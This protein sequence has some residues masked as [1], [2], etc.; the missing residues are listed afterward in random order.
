MYESAGDDAFLREMASVGEVVEAAGDP[1]SDRV[2]FT[3]REAGGT[4]LRLYDD[5]AVRTLDD[6]A[7]LTRGYTH[8]DQRSL[9]WA[10]DGS[11]VV[12]RSACSGTATV[13]WVDAA[14]GEPRPVTGGDV[15]VGQPR[16][17]PD[18]ERLVA[19]SED[20]SPRALV[21][22]PLDG[23][24]GP[25][26]D[27]GASP[28]GDG[29]T[30]LC[31]D[32]VFYDPRWLDESTVV[33]ARLPPH[34]IPDEEMELVA[35]SLD[36]TV[37][38]RHATDGKA[39]APRPAP[40]GDGFA[41]C[42][43]DHGRTGLYRYGSGDV[44]SV[45]A[46]DDADVRTPA[47]SE[48]GRLAVTAFADTNVELRVVNPDGTVETVADAPGRRHFPVW[49]DGHVCAVTSTPTRPFRLRDETAGRE[50]VADRLADPDRL[51]VPRPVECESRDGTAVPATVYYPPG[52]EDAPP[53][54]V[55]VV[56][57][58]HGGPSIFF[59][60]E[61]DRRP[62]YVAGR[63]YV[64]VEPNYRGSSGYGRAFRHASKG[65]WGRGDVDDLVAAADHLAAAHEQ[66]A[67]DRVGL[68]GM[69]HGG[70]LVLRALVE[71]DRFAAGATI[72]GICDLP[73]FVEESDDVGRWFVVGEM[74]T[75]DEHPDR[76]E[77]LSPIHRVDEIDAPVLVVHGAEDD[78][79][80]VS[81]S[82]RL[83]AALDDAG[84]PH[85]YVEFPDEGHVFVGVET[86][87]ATYSRVADLFDGAL[88]EGRR[89]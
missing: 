56:E 82:E 31:A 37:E 48:D 85:E 53:G 24:G 68:F 75:P 6:A 32:H 28:D 79:V 25:V 11:G 49:R 17:S 73:R 80:P 60:Y 8:H 67:G 45:Y 43:D 83:V 59:G 19:V 88:R 39:F 23:G 65:S 41:F 76:Y 2:A 27:D 72:C 35:V 47:W 77:A 78:R 54:S 38:V 66:V 87:V 70:Y 46:P 81:Q 40:D 10:P 50:L 51:V 12:Y 7:V 20:A 33:V 22:V 52:F 4:S 89:S 34:S 9:D 58:V 74:G 42:C 55:P 36:G 44:A 16:V 84:V 26:G 15:P 5:G 86:N 57:H 13:R 21:S 18:G 30:V 3:H 29:R 61:F 64:V 1:S 69:S 62:Q 63:G 71:T 14:G